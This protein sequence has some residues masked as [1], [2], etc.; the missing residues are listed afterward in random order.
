MS[1]FTSLNVLIDISYIKMKCLKL[2]SDYYNLFVTLC[3][4]KLIILFLKQRGQPFSVS[5]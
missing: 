2:I 1:W 3:T 5:S 4:D